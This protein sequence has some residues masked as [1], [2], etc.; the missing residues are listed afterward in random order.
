[1]RRV[2]EEIDVQ[3]ERILDVAIEEFC[4]KGYAGTRMDDIAK[5]LNITK[6]PIYYHFKNKAGLFD[7]AYRRILD[8]VYEN[9]LKIFSKN[10][11]V[12]EKLEEAFVAC[13]I[14][15]CQMQ[16]GEMGHILS[17]ES[18][19]LSD[20]IAYMDEM[21]ARFYQ[22]KAAA[23]K[24][25]QKRGEIKADVDVDELFALINACYSGVLAWVGG[26]AR[27]ESLS[28]EAQ[29]KLAQ[30]MVEKVFEAFRNVY[31]NQ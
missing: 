17:Q 25:A 31:F 6:T 4:E 28:Q 11:S 2:N 18:Q 19:E 16:A 9:D 1:M 12:Y 21:N 5:K 30:S 7:A 15:S 23:M 8:G 29:E 3:N 27:R 14:S 10:C 24:D 26:A 13:A 20:T 22:F